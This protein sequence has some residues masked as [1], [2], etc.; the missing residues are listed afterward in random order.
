MVPMSPYQTRVHE[1]NRKKIIQLLSVQPLT[2]KELI[3]E[4]GLSRA[5]IN[6]HLKD[7]NKDGLLKK[8]YRDRKIL[9]VLQVTELDLVSWFLGQLE[10]LGVPEEVVE[11]GKVLLDDGVLVSSLVIYNSI[12]TNVRK[13]RDRSKILARGAS[14]TMVPSKIEILD[15]EFHPEHEKLQELLKMV[16]AELNPYSFNVCLAAYEREKLFH[17]IQASTK[18][19]SWEC[20]FV[21]M[22][23]DLKT[24]FDKTWEW[25][26]SEVSEYLPSSR[27]LQVLT[28]TYFDMLLSM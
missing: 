6:K 24:R 2:F 4:S 19:E 10:N 28:N 15:V 12:W 11:K 17:E 21:E 1:E 8:E 18:E 23:E 13:I 27:L 22:P 20:F 14:F 7:L 25:W 26:N 5:T 9:N 3:E 16:L